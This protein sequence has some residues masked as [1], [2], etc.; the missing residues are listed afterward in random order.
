[1][2][3]AFAQA[4][5]AT[6][7]IT[8]WLWHQKIFIAPNPALSVPDIF[9]TDAVSFDMHGKP[10]IQSA[11]S[12]AHR[13]GCDTTLKS[14]TVS[15]SAEY[16]NTCA[17][18]KTHCAAIAETAVLAFARLSRCSAPVWAVQDMN[19]MTQPLHLICAL[20]VC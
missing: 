4:L 16:P 18:A 14:C 3:I 6:G 17:K 2:S 7:A 1:M 12:R 20:L 11:N 5:S 9:T 10:T 15:T 13:S 8:V 19:R